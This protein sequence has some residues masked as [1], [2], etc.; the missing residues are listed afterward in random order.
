MRRMATCLALAALM[1]PSVGCGCFRRNST[2]VTAM[3]ITSGCAVCTDACGCG[4][5]NLGGPMMYNGGMFSSP[6]T[7]T[8]EVLP[9]GAQ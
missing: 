5:G 3:P 7:P 8:V 2:H 1:L 9:S 4:S 6:A